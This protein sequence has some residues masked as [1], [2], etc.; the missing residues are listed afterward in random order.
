MDSL[1]QTLTHE[2][3]RCEVDIQLLHIP[4]SSCQSF[5][6]SDIFAY[7]GL[8]ECYDGHG[9]GMSALSCRLGRYSETLKYNVEQSLLLQHLNEQERPGRTGTPVNIHIRST[10]ARRYHV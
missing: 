3:V 4:K 7:I 10:W 9:I 1:Q 6:A 5:F 2:K 8:M